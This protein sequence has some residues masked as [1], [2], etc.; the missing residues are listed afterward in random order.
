MSRDHD[1][2]AKLSQLA[3][4]FL[5]SLLAM[6]DDEVLAEVDQERLAR[7]KTI[8]TEVNA[9]I[10]KRALS[11]ARTE[12]EAW[13]ASQSRRV[14]LLGGPAARSQFEQLRRS[15]SELAKG[16]TLAA[17]KGKAPTDE[18]AAGIIEDLEDL[19]R[20][21]GQDQPE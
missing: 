21:D 2:R 6:P 5:E 9:D 13:T 17:R 14:V 20:L 11:Q 15:N 3:D 8:I 7:V 18:D 16:F 4:A 12:R 1:D 19:K 10:S